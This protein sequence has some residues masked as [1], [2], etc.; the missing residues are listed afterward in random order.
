MAFPGRL[1]PPRFRGNSDPGAGLRPNDRLE[2]P[3]N[4][5]H[6]EMQII[7]RRW[8][9]FRMG[10]FRVLRD[11]NSSIVFLFCLLKKEKMTSRKSQV[12][13]WWTWNLE[14]HLRLCQRRH[15]DERLLVICS[16]ARKEVHRLQKLDKTCIR[17]V[18]W[19][20]TSVSLQLCWVSWVERFSLILKRLR[21]L[22][23]IVTRCERSFRRQD[24]EV[25]ALLGVLQSIGSCGSCQSTLQRLLHRGNGSRSLRTIQDISTYVQYVPQRF[26][27]I[28]RHQYATVLA[29]C[30][31]FCR[32][33]APQISPETGEYQREII[34]SG[35]NPNR[36]TGQ[37]KVG[38][39]FFWIL[40]GCSMF[41]FFFPP[42]CKPPKLL[43]S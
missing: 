17:H 5:I 16:V 14:P 18:K 30:L 13:S 24:I 26:S 11:V 33:W 20:F 35:T 3:Q 41:L 6:S 31:E 15:F 8:G 2:P 40:L 39:D 32:L 21:W 28:L 22:R 34:R 36:K 7:G 43:K 10:V 25:A 27:S 1:R 38:H 42:H 12:F 4:E 9:F 19:V 23:G 37:R 29:L